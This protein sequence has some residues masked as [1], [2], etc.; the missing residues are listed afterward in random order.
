M[1]RQARIFTETDTL[2][3]EESSEEKQPELPYLIIQ[4][5]R[6]VAL[7]IIVSFVNVLHNNLNY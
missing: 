5:S 1:S 2:L 3:K 4:I 7:I 6:L